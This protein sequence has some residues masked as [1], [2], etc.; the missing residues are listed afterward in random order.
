MKYDI[1][2]CAFSSLIS[3]YSCNFGTMQQLSQLRMFSGKEHI[4]K[5]I[6]ISKLLQFCILLSP[7]QKQRISGK[8]SCPSLGHKYIIIDVSRYDYSLL[9]RELSHTLNFQFINNMLDFHNRPFFD[10][11]KATLITFYS[12]APS[13]S[14]VL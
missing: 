9:Q 4:F 2:S 3:P 13:P 14:P 12:I 6:E 1:L 7:K 5:T 11:R 10:K 8:L